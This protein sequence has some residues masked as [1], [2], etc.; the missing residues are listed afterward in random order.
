MGTCGVDDR[1]IHDALR[2]FTTNAPFKLTPDVS[3]WPHTNTLVVD[4]IDVSLDWLKSFLNMP[5]GTLTRHDGRTANPNQVIFTDLTRQRDITHLNTTQYA[6]D[7]A[8]NGLR[9]KMEKLAADLRVYE[10][11]SKKWPYRFLDWLY[12]KLGK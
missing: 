5:T 7:L 11:R 2:M 8:N 10:T 6:F 9:F 3:F 12:R 1:T 4:G